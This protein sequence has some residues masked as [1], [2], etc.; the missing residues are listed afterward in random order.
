MRKLLFVFLILITAVSTTWA[1]AT[2]IYIVRHAEKD[3]A[4][5]NVKDPRLTPEGLKRSFDLSTKLEKDEISAIFSTNY[6]R[7]IQTAE[8]LSKRIKKKIQIYDP[9]IVSD[10]VRTVNNNY[11]GKTVLIVGHSNTI[12]PIIRAFGG[13]TTVTEIKDYDYSYLFKLII[14]DKVN[15]SYEYYGD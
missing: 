9:T 6:I 15:T 11:K 12:L 3:M 5:G 1:Q 13:S 2:T 8:P 4:D 14:D 10:I 7:T